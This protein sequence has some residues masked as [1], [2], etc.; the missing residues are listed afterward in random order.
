MKAKIRLNSVVPN[1]V[2]SGPESAAIDLIYSFLLPKYGQDA[3]SHI[4][5][6]QIGDDLEELIIGDGKKVYINI[7]YPV[8]AD[9]D[10]KSSEEKNLI[11]LDVVHS[12]LIRIAKQDKKLEVEKLLAIRDEILAN[13]FSFEFECKT[14]RNKR[15]EKLVAKIVVHPEMNKF[16]Y[17]VVVEDS[18]ELKCKLIIYSGITVT[19]YFSELFSIG[20]WKSENELIITGKNKEVEIHLLIDECKLSYKNLT[21]YDKPPYYEMMKAGLSEAEKKRA[22]EDWKHSLPPGHAGVLN[23]EPN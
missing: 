6:N 14:Y 11:R 5:I 15:N 1:G 7:R 19:L 18:G 16:D 17:Y 9:F 21:K 22:Y 3:Y 12:A 13:N 23:Y 10:S 20:R 2:G 4:G 8:Y